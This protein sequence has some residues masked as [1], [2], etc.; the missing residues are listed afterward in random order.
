MRPQRR[1]I[2]LPSC[3]GSPS[4]IAS[5]S[6]SPA[7][8]AARPGSGLDDHGLA[9]GAPDGQIAPAAA[10]I[11]EALRPELAR[12]AA[13]A[14]APAARLT[15]PSLAR[16]ASNS[17][18]WRAT[19]S[20]SVCVGRG[21]QHQRPAAAPFRRRAGRAAPGDTA[22]W[23]RRASPALARRRF[24][25]ALPW[26]SQSGTSSRRSGLCLAS[27]NR[28]SSSRSVRT[29]VPSRSTTSG[30]GRSAGGA[31]A[32]VLGSAPA[33]IAARPQ[34]TMLGQPQRAL[35]PRH[36]VR[37]AGRAAELVAMGE[38]PVEVADQR[39]AVRVPRHEA[40]PLLDA[41]DRDEALLA[42]GLVDPP[43]ERRKMQG[44]ERP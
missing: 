31:G 18:R 24:R 41:L 6:G 17:P 23:S 35:L 32:A 39:L 42:G 28:D 27:T 20:A 4:T 37:D 5:T 29:S 2:D 16:T 10:D 30:T 43:V 9:G 34:K 40:E 38:V 3:G 22:G 33:V 11:V 12:P 44:L 14:C 15:V 19:S 21:R 1:Q 26:A 25:Q 36:P 8:C 13:P 7:T